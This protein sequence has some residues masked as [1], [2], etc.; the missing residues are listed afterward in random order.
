VIDVAAEMLDAGILEKSGRLC[1]SHASERLRP[2]PDGGLE[3][4]IAWADQTAIGKDITVTQQDVRA[5]QLA[6]GALYAG[7]QLLLK[8]LGIDRPD[9]VV[10]T[11]AFGSVIDRKRA[12]RIGLFP[13]CGLDN[14]RVVGNAAGDGARSALLNRQKRLEAE[15]LAREIE[16]VE[17]TTEP[18][19][20]HRFVEATQLPHATDRFPSVL[21]G[22]DARGGSEPA[23]GRAS[24][25]GDSR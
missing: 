21:K 6:K 25:Q 17:L 1:A 13:D 7:S 9:R 3:F 22:P 8:R 23:S 19:F 2:S 24:M 11:G 18:E 15:R 5:I 12:L 20:T 16:Y 4:V 10:L 14:V